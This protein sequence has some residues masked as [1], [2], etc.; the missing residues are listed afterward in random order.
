M[1]NIGL[2]FRQ[3]RRNRSLFIGT[4]IFICIML[5]LF[6]TPLFVHF[7][8]YTIQYELILQKPSNIHLLGTDEFGRDVLSRIILGGRVSLYI[9]L[10]VMVGTTFFGV[11]IALLAGY[12][13]K[14]DML[15]M[16]LM[17]IMMAFPSLLLAIA[18]VTVFRNSTLG[19]SIALTVVYTPRT[20]RIVRSQVLVLKNEQ[21][22]DASK[23]IGVNSLK[24]L[25]THILP[26]VLPVLIVQETFLFAY[27]ILGEA[28]ISFVGVGVQPPAPSWGNILGDARVLLREAP[29]LVI[30]PGLAIMFS[31]LS[32]NL[33]GDGLREALDPKRRKGGTRNQ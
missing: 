18:L 5:T 20:V 13:E 7:D 19:V 16:R 24:I 1:N 11:L 17:D 33:I 12:Y 15:V 14:V 9:G 28:G 10:Q 31:V 32:L 8:A 22:V 21:Y 4:I 3:F 27:A 26:G 23:S 2:K 25:F 6:I 30:Y 29:W